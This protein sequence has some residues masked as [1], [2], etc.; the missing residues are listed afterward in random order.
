MTLKVDEVLVPPGLR[1][2][3][4]LRF[5][6]PLDQREIPFDGAADNELNPAV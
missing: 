6:L 2:A 1:D 4:L 5:W 3:L